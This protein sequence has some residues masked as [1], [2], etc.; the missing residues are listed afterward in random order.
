MAG[1]SSTPM[2]RTITLSPMSVGWSF[3]GREVI[4]RVIF[5]SLLKK[6]NTSL[7]VKLNLS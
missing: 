6:D 5:C 4:A 1:Q 2:G 7:A 3:G